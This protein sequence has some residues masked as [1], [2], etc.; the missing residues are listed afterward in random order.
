MAKA[1]DK[2]T[3][4]LAR[5]MGKIERVKRGLSPGDTEDLRF[6]LDRAG[7]W[8]AHALFKRCK[9]GHADEAAVMALI[10]EEV[11]K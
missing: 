6:E 8:V 11:E 2:L 7:Q 4:T 9:T 5:L 3:A 1:V 10:D